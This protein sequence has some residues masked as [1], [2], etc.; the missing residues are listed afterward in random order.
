MSLSPSRGWEEHFHQASLA[1]GYD[2]FSNA[3]SVLGLKAVGQRAFF[4][5]SFLR[6]VL[7]YKII[8]LSL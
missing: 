2:T 6:D 8:N 4:I 7:Y 5:R 3:M 1:D